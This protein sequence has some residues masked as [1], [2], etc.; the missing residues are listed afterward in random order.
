M[1]SISVY[2]RLSADKEMPSP[3]PDPVTQRKPTNSRDN[4][5]QNETTPNRRPSLF[6]T[7]HVSRGSNSGK[8]NHDDVPFDMGWEATC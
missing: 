2:L 7:R 1:V 5:N 6:E 4:N 8:S 3:I